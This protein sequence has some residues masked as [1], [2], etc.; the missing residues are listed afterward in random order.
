MSLCGGA[1]EFV[2]LS[3]SKFFPN[4]LYIEQKNLHIEGFAKEFA[5][6]ANPLPNDNITIWL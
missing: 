4:N 5:T 1:Y 2:R 6:I 3:Y